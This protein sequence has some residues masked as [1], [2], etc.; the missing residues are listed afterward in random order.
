MKALN[1]CQK[2]PEQM[3]RGAASASGMVSFS[4]YLLD[5]DAAGVLD[6]VREHAEQCTVLLT[7]HDTEAERRE[8]E[9]AV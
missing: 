4:D 9:V 5:V 7:I 3:R 6:A 1:E 8:D 2:R